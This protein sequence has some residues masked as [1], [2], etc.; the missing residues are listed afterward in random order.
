[1]R[2]GFG[3]K[4]L[5]SLVRHNA[6][7]LKFHMTNISLKIFMSSLWVRI[8]FICSHE[9]GSHLITAWTCCSSVKIFL[10]TFRSRIILDIPLRCSVIETLGSLRCVSNFK[11]KLLSLVIEV[12][13]K[14]NFNY[15]HM[16]IA[17]G[18]FSNSPMRSSCMLFS[19]I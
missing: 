2:I 3:E 18:K 8:Y 17:V 19:K 12:P 6:I 9:Y 7:H 1:M 5:S 15:S 16:A 14:V 11:T 10:S 13:P 4:S